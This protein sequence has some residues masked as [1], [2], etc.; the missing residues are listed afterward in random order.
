MEDHVIV[1]ACNPPS[2]HRALEADRSIG[3]LPPCNVVVRAESDRTVVQAL[4]PA[5]WSR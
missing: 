4:D 2:A 3:L 1:G 5:R